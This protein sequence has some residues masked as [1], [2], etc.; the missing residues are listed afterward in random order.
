MIFINDQKYTRFKANIINSVTYVICC[1]WGV[2]EEK[3]LSV[4]SDGTM[5]NRDSIIILDELKVEKE[6]TI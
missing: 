1:A 4:I 3:Y 2:D 6:S 5:A